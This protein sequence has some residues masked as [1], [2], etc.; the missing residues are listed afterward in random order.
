MTDEVDAVILTHLAWWKKVGLPMPERLAPEHKAW[1]EG[2]DKGLK[3]GHAAAVAPL[4]GT[5]PCA[6]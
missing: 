5:G 4:P 1:A 6:V 3:D 2:Y